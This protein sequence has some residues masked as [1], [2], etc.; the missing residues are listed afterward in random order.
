MKQTEQDYTV[1]IFRGARANPLR[2]KIRKS[3]VRYSLLAGACLL[4]VQGGVLAHYL[5]QGYQLTELDDLR[6]ELSNSLEKTSRYV[7]EID[8]MKK[9]MVSLEFLNRKLQTMFGLEA[10]EIEGSRDSSSGQGGVEI[11]YEANGSS[12]EI[13]NTP[14]DFGMGQDFNTH[15]LQRHM[16]IAEIAQGLE[17]LNTHAATEKKILDKLSRTASERAEQW[18]STPSIWPVKGEITSKFGPRISPFTGKKALHA[19]VDIGAPRGTKI[20]APAA[21]KVAVAG[22]DTR[23]GKFIRIDHGFGIE[24]TYGHLSKIFVTFGRKIHRGEVIGLVGSTG[25]FS[26]GPHLHYQIAVNDHV[27]NPTQ[28]ILD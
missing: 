1:I 5:Y 19:G 18:A 10:D 15:S 23:M 14:E 7:G 25:R 21:G 13:G 11:P 24:T 17:W 3:L 2:L 8:G 28:Y 4:L 12:I 6:V 16:Q 20:F 26:T 22:H 27:V 9:R